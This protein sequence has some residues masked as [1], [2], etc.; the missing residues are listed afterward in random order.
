MLASD[1]LTV[2][3]ISDFGATGICAARRRG[4]SW[5]SGHLHDRSPKSRVVPHLPVPR[6]HRLPLPWVWD[7]PCPAP[8]VSRRHRQ[9]TWIQPVHDLVATVHCLF[10]RL[11][12]YKGVSIAN[13]ARSV[14]LTP[15]DM[16]A[17]SGASG[18]LGTAKRA[19]RSVDRP[20]AIGRLHAPN[21][22]LAA[23]YSSGVFRSSR[24][25]GSPITTS[26]TSP[27]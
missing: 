10:L 5:D 21:R 9:R 11:R 23:S 26:L 6:S 13:A 2:W 18:V 7:A 15:V 20:G 3:G 24:T 14:H 12:N 27:R 17:T 1:T 4:S 22:I 8:I 19:H 16:G 25:I